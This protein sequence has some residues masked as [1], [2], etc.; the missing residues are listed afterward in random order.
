MVAYRNFRNSEELCDW[1]EE[2]FQPV[3]CRRE[4]RLHLDFPSRLTLALPFL[5]GICVGVVGGA[6]TGILFG[7]GSIPI[8]LASYLLV[9]WIR[10]GRR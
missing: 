4:G 10:R 5:I 6:K 1:I 2:E 7:I 3:K 9:E 8:V